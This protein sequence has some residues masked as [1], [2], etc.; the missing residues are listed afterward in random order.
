MLVLLAACTVGYFNWRLGQI[1]RIELGLA[2][3]APGGPENYLIVG[4][5]TRSGIDADDP[6]AGAFL[7][8]D[9]Y[10]ADPDGAGRRSDTIMIMRIDPS[11][12]AAQLLSFPRDLYVPIAGTDHSDKINAAFG[13]GVPTLVDTIQ[14][15]FRIPINHYV[16]VDF[17]GFQNLID[18]MGGV[19]LYFDKPMWDDHTGLN[20]ATV[21]CH[22]LD[23]SQALAFARSR[24]LWYNT[25]GWDEVDTSSLRYM[26]DSPSQ[27]EANGW[28]RDGTSDLGRISRQQLLIRS[29]IPQAERAAFRNPTTL[30]AIMASVV[31]SVKVDEG[32]S[33]GRLMELANRFRNFDPDE[34]TTYS[35]PGT[36]EHSP[37]AGDILV[38]DTR[39]AES[40]LATFR[41]EPTPGPQAGVSVRVLNA[42]GV[43]LQAAN[44]AGALERVGFT[45]EGTADASTVGIEE[46]DVTQVRY[47]PANEFNAR[48]VAKHLSAPV[49]LV[50]LEGATSNVIEVVTGANFTT[51]STELRPLDESEL[52]PTTTAATGAESSGGGAESPTS[53]TTSTTVIGV[54]PE[55]DRSC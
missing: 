55:Q 51:V 1:D 36:P 4:S 53:S 49:Q 19:D 20:I 40:M 26:V 32:L 34:L 29:A 25:L 24:Y 31:D 23:G 11:T 30:N 37:H 6:T 3:A 46:L 38:P 42:S 44:V 33:S 54:V 14:E 21:G 48:V 35:F 50:P 10:R 39:A 2:S 12:K 47:A 28:Y 17:V 27:M 16:E 22:S 18:A 52:A 43:N 41:G 13:I 7:D 5:D 45:I 15:N 8:D 9:Q